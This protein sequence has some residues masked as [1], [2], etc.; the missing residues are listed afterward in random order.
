MSYPT[1]AHPVADLVPKRRSVRDFRPDPIPQDLLDALLASANQAPSWANTQPYRIAVASGAMRDQLATELCARFD[2]GMRAQQSG[3]LGRLRLLVK[4]GGMPD[5]D[6]STTFEYPADLQVARRATGHGLYSLLGI[7]RSDHAA[8][9][10]Q[11]RRN[12]EFFGAPTVIFLFI[13]GGLHEFAVLD[14]GIWL[15][16]LMLSAPALG[17]D[18]C[19]QGALATWGGPVRAAFEVPKGYKLMCGAAIGYASGHLINQYTP[20]RPDHRLLQLAPKKA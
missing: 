19:A 6:F 9:N 8:R 5:G 20:G 15:Q 4:P 11:M 1:P 3:W 17:L 7:A 16:T 2:A 13:H 18:T 12:F 14:A 10:S